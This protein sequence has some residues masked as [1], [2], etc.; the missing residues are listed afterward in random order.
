MNKSI[1]V[2]IPTFNEALNISELVHKIFLLHKEIDILIIDDNSPDSTAN[3]VRDLS[4]E[5]PSL[6]MIKRPRKLGVGSAHKD[7]FIYARENK[8]KYL[9]TMD[10]DFTH[11]PEDIQNFITVIQECDIVVGSRF[12]NGNGVRDW[13]VY[14]KLMTYL[15]HYITY[16]FLGI[17]FDASGAFRAYNLKSIDMQIIKSTTSNGYSFFIES[18]FLFFK[19]NL[20]IK[21]VP[22]VL[23]KRTYGDSKMG[24]SDIV[25]TL[26]TI[27]KLVITNV[28]Y[29]EQFKICKNNLRTN[30]IDDPQN[31]D[32]Y[33]N[34]SSC[35]E[36]KIYN[37]I[38]SLY[39]NLVIK[40]RLNRYVTK[41]FN[42][43][44]NLLHAGCG[45]G[46]V[47][48]DIQNLMNITAIDISKVALDRYSRNIY[49]SRNIT[50]GSIMN[51]PFENDYF[52]GIY[53]LGVMEHFSEDEIIRILS[54]FK[55]VLKINGKVL[56]FWPHKNASSVFVLRIAGY[57]LSKL[58]LKSTFH[59]P[60][61]SLIKS[62]KEACRYALN[63]GLKLTD[64]TFGFKDG[65]IQSAITL[66]KIN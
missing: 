21:E 9:I 35:T 14:R 48:L 18:A 33:W 23:P 12:I 58:N 53:N 62:K 66:Q 24:F 25:N 45:S 5:Y 50:H 42:L 46:Q 13:S 60:E 55:R 43:G 34:K 15:G 49:K 3:K 54:E 64:Y 36:S 39:R 32:E 19:N 26:K 10:S 27:K 4:S 7:A 65:F 2:F 37:I 59:P 63:A 1:L 31:W 6:S 44:D 11:K 30:I 47:D 17:P 22:I 16:Y 28:V 61:P 8:Y 52:E 20:K 38:A 40:K 41:T 51:M 29:P 57:F 56:L